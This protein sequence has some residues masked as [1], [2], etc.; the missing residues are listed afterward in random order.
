M[1][2]DEIRKSHD[3]DAMCCCGIT[4]GEHHG[5]DCD[6]PTSERKFKLVADPATNQKADVKHGE[7]GFRRRVRNHNPGWGQPLYFDSISGAEESFKRVT[8]IQGKDFVTLAAWS[9]RRGLWVPIE[10]HGRSE[11]VSAYK[12]RFYNIHGATLECLQEDLRAAGVTVH[13]GG[14]RC[15]ECCKDKFK[16]SSVPPGFREGGSFKVPR[17]KAAP[18]GIVRMRECACKELGC[19]GKCGGKKFPR[20][21]VNP[22]VY[23]SKRRTVAELE[24]AYV[25]AMND[26]FNVLGDK[27]AVKFIAKSIGSKGRSL[28]WSAEVTRRLAEREAEPREGHHARSVVTCQGD[29]LEDWE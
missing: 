15:T 8:E 11:Q 25:G 7:Q 10:M 9:D 17:S 21:N 6:Y 1:T 19:G 18:Q 16:S 20:V 5:F 4:W 27:A 13:G 23:D 29:F 2:T 24:T 28:F 26:L 22:V 12:K 14:C 3:M